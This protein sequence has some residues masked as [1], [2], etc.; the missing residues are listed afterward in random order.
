MRA[1]ACN[2]A[3]VGRHRHES[4]APDTRQAHDTIFKDLNFYSGS[5]AAIT[6]AVYSGLVVIR[7]QQPPTRRERG[8]AGAEAPRPRPKHQ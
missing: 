5:P 8:Y 6:A 7:A 3:D 4:R 1:Q 2:R